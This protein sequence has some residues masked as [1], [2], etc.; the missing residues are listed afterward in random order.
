MSRRPH[1][2]LH[3]S[4]SNFVG[5]PEKQIL[6]HASQDRSPEFEF[7]VGSFRDGPDTPEV[8]QRA[9]VLGLPTIELGSGK[10][11][12]VAVFQLLRLL[13]E[14]DIALFCTHS[15]K[16]NIIGYLASQFTGRPHLAFVRGWTGEDFRVRMYEKLERAVL[17]HTA[18]VLCVSN[19]QAEQLSASRRRERPP[20]V[21]PNAI[22][23][24]NAVDA[25]A[26][27]ELRR[28]LQLPSEAFI[29]GA[30]GRLSIEKGHRFLIESAAILRKRIPSLQVVILGSGPERPSLERQRGQLRLDSCV[31]MPGFKANVQEWMGACDVIVNPSLTEGMPNVLLE[32]MA[33]SLPTV[34]TAVGGVPDMVD[35]Q[36]SGLLIAP[37]DVAAIVDTIWQLYSHPDKAEVMGRAART[38]V[39]RFSPGSQR[40][41]WARVYAEALNLPP[42]GWLE[43]AEPTGSQDL[44]LISVVIPVRNEAL[45]I[46]TVLDDLLRQDYPLDRFELLIAD[47]NS[48]DAT[49]Q[50][51]LDYTAHC[52]V[53]LRLLR[54]P[55]GWSSAG[56][57]AGTVVSRGNIVIF[58]DGHCRIHNTGMLAAAAK[59]ITER[60]AD[61]LSRPQPLINETNSWFQDVI[62]NVRS[63]PIAHSVGS[64]IYGEE[65]A[66]V[67]PTSAGF[68]YC[69]SVFAEVGLFDETFD[70]CEDLELNYRVH[71][72][73]MCCYSSPQF[74]VNYSPRDTLR[75]FFFQLLR[76]G[77]GRVRFLRKHPA[78][79][80]LSQAVPAAFVAWLAVGAAASCFSHAF[81]H[82]YEGTVGLYVSI[83]MGYS[84][85]LA[86]RHG[87]RNLLAAPAAFFATHLALGC[88]FWAEALGVPEAR[89]HL[90][91]REDTEASQQDGSA[92]VRASDAARS[93]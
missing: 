63:T 19:E 41:V 22:E 46:A 12:P 23:L 59:M 14:H 77:R 74:A 42:A 28:K 48:T 8:L 93:S 58:V 30:A 66:Q 57:N 84:I 18:R 6:R 79:A 26:R 55:K 17:R 71:R 35:H 40:S 33:L 92:R 5:G 24:P 73:G 64:K 43:Q 87:W 16:A 78:A 4:A 86:I 39:Q 56:R 44:P 62:A 54:N 82:V 81:A 29:V 31:L 34:A 2:I 89:R 32:A 50:V 47:G 13:R 68:G 45:H 90:G 69:R 61:C 20:T 70:A 65:E 1:R 27:A 7:W 76:Y 67:D 91:N 9:Q 85:Q 21:V 53:P 37:S 11:I 75:G 80:T 3:L 51:V 10:L 36:E 49:W 38:G 88:G 15:Y 83:I 25:A 60:A 52:K 72:S